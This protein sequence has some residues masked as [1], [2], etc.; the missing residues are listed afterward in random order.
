MFEQPRVNA[1]A[2][3]NA[4][5]RPP[6]LF[7]EGQ[8]QQVPQQGNGGGIF[9]RIVGAAG[10]PPIVPGQF[11][12]G[13]GQAQPPQQAQFG[14]APG[15]NGIPQQGTTLLPRHQLF[16]AQ[17][18]RFEGFM[19]PNGN[20]VPW[21]RLDGDRVVRPEAPAGTAGAVPS[22]TENS[23]GGV[24]DGRPSGSS[25]SAPGQSD[26]SRR[27]PTDGSSPTSPVPSSQDSSSTSAREA[28]RAA[29]LRRFDSSGSSVSRPA[30]KLEPNTRAPNN[31]STTSANENVPPSPETPRTGIQTQDNVTPTM[32]NQG[33]FVAP[34]FIPLYDP[35][36]AN[37]LPSSSQSAS[38]PAA[39]PNLSN[40]D[41]Q[42]A[43]R[44]V[45]A[46]ELQAQVQSILQTDPLTRLQQ[47]SGQNIRDLPRQLSVDQLTSL[48]QLTREAI[49][50]RL[51]LLENVEAAAA[52]CI[53][54][55]LR[56][57]S[58]LPRSNPVPSQT[59]QAISRP[60]GEREA[61]SSQHDTT[62]TTASEEVS[63]STQGIPTPTQAETT[64]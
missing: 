42:Q 20:W 6:N 54:E 29:A 15:Q 38:S 18:E 43:G 64:A 30:P 26:P 31:I 27:G 50:E 47:L 62:G 63:T 35:K 61:S 56:C 8:G 4:N 3:A 55:L 44:Q 22:T 52:R 32:T 33:L 40:S 21:P 57:R 11:A 7:A 5:Q 25:S 2:N 36:V 49:D 13:P 12:Q 34:E 23:P 10:A 9:G 17:P 1:N 39:A 41:N 19:L 51:R 48:D 58:V 24:A 46:S 45:S 37:P 59:A 60:N 53:T 16:V 28:A 14:T